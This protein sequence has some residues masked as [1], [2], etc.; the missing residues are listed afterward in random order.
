MH[1]D[2]FVDPLRFLSECHGRIRLRLAT[3]RETA[4]AL[5][6]ATS[7]PRHAVEAAL[8]FFHTSGAAHT[9]DEEES[10]FP[11]LRS[12]LRETGEDEGLATLEGL[13]AEHRLHEATLAR[14]E[15]GLR[16]LDPALGDGDGLPDPD[17]PP[18]AAG[19]AEAIEVAA[20]LEAMV[21]QYE[22]HI[23]LEDDY[24]FP[25]A[26][27][28]LAAAEQEAIAIEMRRRHSLGSKLL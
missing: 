20:A 26:R 6:G 16:A 21:E 2:P 25:L 17:A 7:I 8:L 22:A 9:V 4:A 24:L 15:R 14:L 3:F 27:R 18:L 28:A 1:A 10:L 5:R 11:R 13:E 12:R 19:T 23:P